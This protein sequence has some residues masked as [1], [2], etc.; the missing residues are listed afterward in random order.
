MAD[1]D[2][3]VEMVDGITIDGSSSGGAAVGDDPIVSEREV[4]VNSIVLSDTDSVVIS[5][6][7]I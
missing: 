5:T 6:D 1:D 7:H 2:P 4:E 3:E